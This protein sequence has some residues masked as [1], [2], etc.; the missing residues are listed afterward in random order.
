MDNYENPLPGKIYISPRLKDFREKDRK[1]RIA[2]KVIDSPDAYAFGTIKNEVVIRYYE[3]QKNYI[4]AKFFEDNREIF[5]LS[6][7]GYSVATDKPHNASFSFVG[8]EI[9]TLHEFISNV[10][11]VELTSACGI[12][13]A[14]EELAKLTLTERQAQHLVEDNQE[15]FAEAVRSLVTTKDIIAVGYR[16]RQLEVFRR[17]LEEEE[18]F[19]EIRD[20]LKATDEALWQKFFEKNPWIFGYGLN[21]VYLQNLDEK[22]LEQVV[23]GASVAC[24]GKRVDGL[25]RTKGAISS[26]CFVEIKTHQTAL[27]GREYRAGCWSQSTELAGAVAQVHGTVAAAMDTIK[28]KLVLED[29]E[30]Y[31]IGEEAFNYAP[32]SYLVVGNLRELQGEHGVNTKKLRSFEIFRRN[33]TSPEIITF[34]ELFQR[35]KFI[36]EL[37]EVA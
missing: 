1:V 26:L 33:L 2:S 24:P 5:V 6:I 16:R 28:E 8:K 32:K 11:A 35:A 4:T 22:K 27:L 29:K 13:I 21:Y 37:S 3:G 36:V 17:L 14:D 18:Y 23:Q 20:R 30:G 12:N 25:M 31:P 15:L 34:D 10:Q 9:E 7:Q 19:S